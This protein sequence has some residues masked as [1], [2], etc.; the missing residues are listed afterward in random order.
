MLHRP[1][2][3]LLDIGLPGLDG[4]QVAE[5]LRRDERLRSVRIIAISGYPPEMFKG[6]I[7]AMGFDHHLVKPV[8]F[9]NLLPLLRV[10][11]N[12]PDISQESV[13]SRGA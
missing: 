7:G 13:R 11:R 10:P 5:K 9:D 2:I 1:D 4:F 8:D 6:K 12:K 3:V